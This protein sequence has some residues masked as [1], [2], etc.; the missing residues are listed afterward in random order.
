VYKSKIYELSNRLWALKN[1][2]LLGGIIQSSIDPALTQLDEYIKKIEKIENEPK[3]FIDKFES[4]REAEKNIRKQEK[5]LKLLEDV[6][7][8][9]VS[10]RSLSTALSTL[11]EHLYREITDKEMPFLITSGGGDLKT[12]PYLGDDDEK[13]VVGTIGMPLYSVSHIDEWI[14]AGHELGH[15]LANKKFG[16]PLE[17]TDKKQNY[18]MEL[19]CDKIALQI[20]GPAFLEALVMKL[21]GTEYGTGLSSFEFG[22]P[23]H[24]R[25]S[26]RIW[27][28]YYQAISFE[29]SEAKP[30]IN[31]IKSIIDDDV[32]PRPNDEL[33]REIKDHFDTETY[34]L[35]KEIRSI[36]D[37][38]GCYRN[39]SELSSKW[40]E[41]DYDTDLE[42]YTPDQIVIAGYL[43][44]RE[45]PQEHWLYTQ[46]VIN[47][48][49]RIKK[50]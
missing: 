35:Y 20:F 36:G 31:S 22:A 11:F 4:I 1:N 34:D 23:N 48:L 37:L 19:L 16:I 17:Y 32:Y 12:F 2:N 50:D 27:I 15:I 47:S 3:P 24:P 29:F 44:S 41:D 14:L 9:F 26:W 7:A 33:F 40:I 6:T 49:I 39:A 8:T 21:T 13:I 43:A 30:F 46:R 25:E 10:N 42:S 18:I 45:N 5:I 28:C 38:K